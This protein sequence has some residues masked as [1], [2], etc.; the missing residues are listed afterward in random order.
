MLKD[1]VQSAAEPETRFPPFLDKYSPSV[2]GK[3]DTEEACCPRWTKRKWQNS[4]TR[5]NL[6]GARKAAEEH[7]KSASIHMRQAH[8]SLG[9][10][11]CPHK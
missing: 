6:T 9:V 7:P 10:I 11:F 3:A 2:I 1:R 4:K 8:I 5:K